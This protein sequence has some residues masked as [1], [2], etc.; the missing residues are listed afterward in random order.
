MF[1]DTRASSCH[2]I[3]IY[4]QFCRSETFV[5]MQDA[6]SRWVSAASELDAVEVPAA[7]H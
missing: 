4:R 1:R 5:F 3:D 7:L 2:R 6:F